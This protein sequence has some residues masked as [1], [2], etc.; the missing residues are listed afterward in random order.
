MA[1]PGRESEKLLARVARQGQDWSAKAFP[2][3][4]YALGGQGVGVPVR[5]SVSSFGPILLSKVLGLNKVQESSLGLVFHYADK[6]GLALLDL[7]DLIELLKYLISDEGKPELKGIGGI[8][9]ATVGVILRSLVTLSD[10]GADVFF[11]EPEFDPDDLLR[12]APDGRGV[13]SLLEL[14]AA[15]HAPGAVL[16][17]PDV[18]AGGPLHL[19]ARGR[20]HRQAEAGVL[21]RRGPPPVQGGLRRLPRRHHP[22][23]APYPLQGR[24]HLLRHPDAQG[25]PRRRAGPAGI[26]RAAPAPRPHPQRREGAAGDGVDLPHLRLRPSGGAAA[27]RHRRGHRHGDEREGC[28]DPGGV[29]AHLGPGVADGAHPRGPVAGRGGAVHAH[30]E[31]RHPAGPALRLR[32][33]HPEAGRRAPPRGGRAPRGR[34]ARA[35][36]S[37]WRRS[38]RPPTRSGPDARRRPSRSRP[39]GSGRRARRRRP[40]V[41][42]SGRTRAWWNR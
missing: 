8:S 20:R 7:K 26:A 3:E 28:T 15:G 23:G 33:P 41:A 4:F 12:V 24:R 2:C 35:A 11:G 37:S 42:T 14:P 13:V 21:L 27:A 18:A 38:W 16:H 10:Q 22:D 9:T 29:D 19:A 17:V 40:A 1:S 36:S 30:R 34:A 31:V 5:A 25:R 39:D 6:A 32:D